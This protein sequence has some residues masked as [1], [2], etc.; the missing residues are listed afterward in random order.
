ML[1]KNHL[2]TKKVLI[3]RPILFASPHVSA[4]GAQ[5]LGQ[6]GQDFDLV[7]GTWSSA[8]DCM[9]IPQNLKHRLEKNRQTWHWPKNEA[10]L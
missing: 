4:D 5:L 9:C 1:G 3:V 2:K 6:E 10:K 8:G 7:D